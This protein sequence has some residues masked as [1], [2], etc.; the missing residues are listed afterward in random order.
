MT[1]L[2]VGR[3]GQLGARLA[4]ALTALGEV[5]AVGRSELDVSRAGDVRALIRDAKPA[6]I[7]NAAAYTAVDRAETEREL[8]MQVNAAAPGVMAEEARRLG[9]LL[10]HYSTDY[11][12][13]GAKHAP[14]T[15]EDA[16]RPVN[17]YGV[18]KLAG[19]DA[20]RASG[21]AHLILRTSW[22]YD[23]RGA[24]FVLTMLRLAREKS[25]LRVVADQT[26]SPTWARALCDASIA[27]LRDEAVRDKSGVY[28]L[29]AEGSV[30]RYELARAI[31]ESGRTHVAPQGR[32]A[33]VVP[34]A[35]SDYPLPAQRPL[36]CVMSK[37]RIARTFGLELTHWSE[38]LRACFD[39]MHAAGGP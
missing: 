16:C 17:F 8:A 7:V 14:Y 27:L 33:S 10:V 28:H 37:E 15:E 32:W 18:S 12:F 38:Q 4:R 11:V 19:E 36:S 20:V 21:C 23:L 31:I 29:A 34:I 25:E 24:N 30:S 6:L 22:V 26:G 1:I 9:A 39:E 5:V 13:D 35:T 3:N 2:L